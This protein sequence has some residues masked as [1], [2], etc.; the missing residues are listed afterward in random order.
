[1]GRRLV[2]I[3]VNGVAYEAEVED[4]MLLA[5]F[6]RDIAGARSVAIGC[7]SGFCGA[8]TVIMDGVLVKSCLVLAVQADGSSILT[9]EGLSRGKALHPIQEAFVENLAPQCGF[10]IPGMIMTT[11]YMLQ[12]KPD[13]TD[14]EVR[15]FLVGNICACC[16]YTN[17]VKAV[18]AAAEKLRRGARS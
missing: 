8:C 11:Y 6:L 15:R 3:T 14:D 13:V 12:R 1:M 9:V 4:R 5:Q 18:K 2:K 17:I 7:G 16:G 10:C